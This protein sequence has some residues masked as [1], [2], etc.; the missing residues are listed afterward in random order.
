MTTGPVRM[1]LAVADDHE[2]GRPI[3]RKD[4]RAPQG[5]LPPSAT[6]SRDVPSGSAMPPPP[7]P[8]WPRRSSASPDH[9]AAVRVIHVLVYGETPNTDC[10]SNRTAAVPAGAGV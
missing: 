2:H 8:P 3:A 4:W 10:R 6:A 7:K 9:D 1:P 5:Y